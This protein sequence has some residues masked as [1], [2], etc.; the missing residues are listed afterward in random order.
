MSPSIV[1]QFALTATAVGSHL[2]AQ[3]VR[4]AAS[5]AGL[6]AD[7]LLRHTMEAIR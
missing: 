2:C 5:L 4:T 1:R 3:A 6:S 7:S